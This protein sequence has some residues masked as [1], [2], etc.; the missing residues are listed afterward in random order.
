MA[1]KKVPFTKL[2]LDLTP[3]VVELKVNEEIVIEVKQFLPTFE[4]FRLVNMVVTESILNGIVN[5]MLLDYTLDRAILMAYTNIGFT[6]K[7][8][9]SDVPYDRILA[10]GLFDK[11]W[12]TI[13]ESERQIIFEGVKVLTEK[14]DK[15]LA[16][17]FSGMGAQ[18]K[19]FEDFKQF[20]IADNPFTK[21]LEDQGVI[22]PQE[23]A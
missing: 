20:L 6:Q 8:L 18:T 16:S 2:G 14:T 3:G 22:P 9:E 15:V 7:Q 13:P 5:P 23:D 12:D 10:S 1:N 19:Q 4:K 21:E 11:I 17:M